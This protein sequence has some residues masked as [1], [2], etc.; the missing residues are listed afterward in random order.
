MKA[1]KVLQQ[2]WRNELLTCGI[3]VCLFSLDAPRIKPL[4][5]AVGDL[6]RQF[7]SLKEELGELTS[8]FDS[9]EAFV[10]DLKEGRVT[11]RQVHR[12]PNFIGLRS[13]LRAQMRA[14]IREIAQ[15]PTLTRARRKG[16]T[17]P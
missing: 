12:R 2:S 5:D 11:R 13:P 3:F 15:N 14:P 1:P 10:D 9:L 4:S 8:K 17:R 7:N 6:Y 16:P